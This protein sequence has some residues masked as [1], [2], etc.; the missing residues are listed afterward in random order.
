MCVLQLVAFVLNLAN[1]LE[2][3]GYACEQHHNFRQNINGTF[4]IYIYIYIQLCVSEEQQ[5]EA[6]HD[7]PGELNAQVGKAAR[8]MLIPALAG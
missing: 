2:D 8:A 4:N 3:H 1:V 6:V 5:H 7:K